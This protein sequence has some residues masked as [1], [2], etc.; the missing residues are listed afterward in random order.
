MPFRKQKKK[1]EKKERTMQSKFWGAEGIS[2]ERFIDP[3]VMNEADARVPAHLYEYASDAISQLTVCF[4]E[5]PSFQ[6]YTC[7][8][9]GRYGSFVSHTQYPY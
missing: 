4:N 6:R 1:E 3:I 7:I 5:R 2:S 9:T 8:I